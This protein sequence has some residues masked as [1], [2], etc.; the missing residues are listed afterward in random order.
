MK[1]GWVYLFP[2][3]LF[4]LLFLGSGIWLND[5]YAISSVFWIFL[6]LIVTFLFFDGSFQEKFDTFLEGVSDRNILLMCVIFVLS[7]VF[8]SLCKANGSID[9]LTYLLLDIIAPQYIFVTVFLLSCSLSFA[10]GTSVGTI[11]ALAPIVF[12]M[13]LNNPEALVILGGSLLGGS[14]FGDNLS[15]I[16][17]TTIAAT[18]TMHVSM[19]DKLKANA[20]IALIAAGITCVV[21]LTFSVEYTH[22]TIKPEQT[23]IWLH[24]PYV[25]V[26]VLALLGIHVVKVLIL[27]SILAFEIVFWQLSD[28][29]TATQTVFVGMQSM[30]EIVILSLCIGGLA[31]MISKAGGIQYII[32]ILQKW[33]GNR[34]KR[35]PIVIATLV[36]AINFTVA[37]NTISLLIS[38]PIA[39]NISEFYHLNKPR[40]TSLLDIFSCIV[41]GL[42]PYGAQVLILI[43]LF[44]KKISYTDLIAHSYY[45]WLLFGVTII[46]L[47][48]SYRKPV[49]N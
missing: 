32:D 25:L 48:I 2:L 10:L 45:I 6:V 38:G 47:F 36:S 15:L 28:F 31:Q 5:F 43:N 12:Q 8:T 29:T 14:M 46:S 18:Q 41:Q 39:H 16:S 22:S 11:V 1:Q 40:V 42:I 17:D 23:S 49:S 4:V 27:C 26:V 7:G 21:L 19:K 9:Y 37:N 13:G 20:I 44:E 24:V 35:A 30:F 33:I 3:L 34:P